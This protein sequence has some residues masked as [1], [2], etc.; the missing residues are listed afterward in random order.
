[1][2]KDKHVKG[3]IETESSS[4]S[5]SEET[6][7]R[8]VRES[9]LK[10]D[11][12]WW[13]L[14]CLV[15]MAFITL[16]FFDYIRLRQESVYKYDVAY[17]KMFHNGTW[18]VE[19]NDS[20][21]SRELL[22]ATID[23]ILST[24]VQ[25][26]YGEDKHTVQYDFGFSSLLMSPELNTYFTSAEGF[27]APQ[28]AADI[29]S[30]MVCPTIQYEVGVIDHF[31]SN[32]SQFGTEEGTIYQTNIFATRKIKWQAG[33][34]KNDS[35]KDRHIRVKWRLMTPRE[36]KARVNM[37]GGKDWLRIDPVG[38]EILDYEELEQN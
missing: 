37:D 33:L 1:M 22:P 23:S 24:W 35:E 25:K 9:S 12:N 4:H 29:A 19:F 14:M 10:T 6:L 17:V 3:K 13:A 21:R 30:C 16:L 38:L 5:V 8:V 26:R 15:L 32:P 11:R 27:N 18:D 36:I 34:N 2:S 7:R 20:E 31:D 28:K